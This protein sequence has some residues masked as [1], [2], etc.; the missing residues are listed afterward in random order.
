MSHPIPGIARKAQAVPE[1]KDLRR[2]AVKG[3]FLQ[4]VGEHTLKGCAGTLEMFT[5][6][7]QNLLALCS[8]LSHA[9]ENVHFAVSQSYRSLGHMDFTSPLVAAAPKDNQEP[10]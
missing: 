9:T 7:G 2:A 3:S 10:S 1:R 4:R 5:F 6:L 8:A